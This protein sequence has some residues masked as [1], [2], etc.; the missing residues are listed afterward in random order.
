MDSSSS[1]PSTPCLTLT[2]LFRHRYLSVT[3]AQNNKQQEK[4]NSFSIEMNLCQKNK[5]KTI[6]ENIP[7]NKF[8]SVLCNVVLCCVL[9]VHLHEYIYI[10]FCQ[11][12]YNFP[13]L[14]AVLYMDFCLVIMEHPLL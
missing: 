10:Y 6:E 2:R 5:K 11:N 8:K 7:P 9:N 4:N 12:V 14:F 1:C 13:L 3:E